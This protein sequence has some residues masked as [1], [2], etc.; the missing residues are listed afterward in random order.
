M[1]KVLILLLCLA[2][3]LSLCFAGAE[4][5]T[6]LTADP[7]PW[8]MSPAPA[9]SP[10]GFTDT[11]Y[12]DPTIRATLETVEEEGIIWRV[13]R[14]EIA[15]PTQLRTWTASPEKLLSQRT[16]SVSKMAAAANAV[17][18][19][20]G[21][22]YMNDPREASVEYRMGQKI[23][24]KAYREKD[25][26]LIDD[27]GDFHL[28][29]PEGRQTNAQQLAILEEA[30]A[31]WHVMN[32]FT[33]GP[34]LVIDGA[35]QEINPRYSYTPNRKDPRAA[36]GQT[37]PLRYVLVLA[38][39]RGESSGAT[40]VELADFMARL[41]CLQAYNLDGGNSSQL[42][43]GS[44]AFKGQSAA[45]DRGLNDIIYFGSAMQ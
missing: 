24:H 8:D 19:I 42:V 1:K 11:S 23:R 4:E 39:G 13:A 14:V 20:N 18:A 40:M 41:G 45:S 43:F 5:T 3:T 31:T 21:D 7:L 15:S 34:A 32:A 44:Q 27:Q 10:E 6:G 28:I 35:V 33:F 17:V 2:F 25:V 38:E 29:R 12:A 9:P 36:I 30:F 22:Y 26:L 37:G 16:A